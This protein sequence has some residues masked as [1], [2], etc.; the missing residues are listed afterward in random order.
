MIRKHWG[1]NISYVR[2]VRDNM[3]ILD[4]LKLDDSSISFERQF[5]AC[6]CVD[7]SASMNDFNKIDKL[8][9]ALRS[10]IEKNSHEIK[11]ADTLNLAIVSFGGP[12]AKVVQAF[13]NIKKIKYKKLEGDGMTSMGDGV[14]LAID[15]LLDEKS[16][17]N[18]RGNKT[19]RPLLIIISDGVSTDDLSKAIERE[20]EL[21]SNHKL[22]VVC[23]GINVDDDENAKNDLKKF[24]PNSEVKTLKE[25]ELEKF[26]E[27]ISRSIEGVSSDFIGADLEL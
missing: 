1:M 18:T 3:A 23:V 26:T 22:N 7:T 27:Y 9:D 21:V 13:E 19:Y 12:K 16:K 8:N 4:D 20:N 10:Y 24:C 25:F 6:F 11:M 5:I 17:W 14:N 2:S 15:L